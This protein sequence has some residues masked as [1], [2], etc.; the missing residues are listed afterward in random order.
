MS[1]RLRQGIVVGYFVALAILVYLRMAGVIAVP[2]WLV[3]GPLWM[4]VMSLGAVLIIYSFLDMLDR[5][6]R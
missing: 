5:V 3:L 4:P 1:E 6:S 2:W